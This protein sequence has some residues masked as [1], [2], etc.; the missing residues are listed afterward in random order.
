MYICT[1]R[2]LLCKYADAA[3]IWEYISSDRTVVCR[4]KS[5]AD[6]VV[7]GD[8]S[9]SGVPGTASIRITRSRLTYSSRLRGRPHRLDTLGLLPDALHTPFLGE[10]RRG[11]RNLGECLT[12]LG[13]GP[14]L[15]RT[16]KRPWTTL[17]RLVRQISSLIDFGPNVSLMFWSDDNYHSRLYIDKNKNIDLKKERKIIKK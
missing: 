9:R 3:Y 1:N 2:Q 11:L 14:E 7:C 6:L 8:D 4:G 12:C 13:Y 10:C 16:L 5:G 15:E 17:V